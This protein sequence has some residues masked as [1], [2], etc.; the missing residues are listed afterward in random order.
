LLASRKKLGKSGEKVMIHK[1]Q[2][3]MICLSTQIV[4]QIELVTICN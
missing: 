2:I 1:S 4:L 3:S